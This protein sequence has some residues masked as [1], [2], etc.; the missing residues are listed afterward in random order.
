MLS[1]SGFDVTAA[2]LFVVGCVLLF[3]VR[4]I[5]TRPKQ[6]THNRKEPDE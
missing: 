4:Y 2:A 6:S 3:C 1:V 5:G